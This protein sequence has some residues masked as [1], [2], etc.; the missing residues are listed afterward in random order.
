RGPMDNAI[1]SMFGKGMMA[2]EV[3]AAINPYIF[4]H[5][6]WADNGSSIVSKDRAMMLTGSLT[7]R[8]MAIAVA[9]VKVIL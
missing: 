6:C 9:A 4:R 2:S 8:K 3:G 7:P 5:R 1:G